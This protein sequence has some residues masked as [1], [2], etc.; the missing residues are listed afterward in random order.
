MDRPLQ[1]LRTLPVWLDILKD[2]ERLAPR[3][4]VMNYTNPVSLTVLAGVRAS[5]LH[6]VGL[7]HSIQ[8]TSQQL[9]DYLGLP[10]EEIDWRAA[11]INH[12]SWFVQLR[13]R[14]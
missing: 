4:L 7:C 9:A 6:I 11:G 12:L 13:T 5:S 1:A 10:Y 14:S 3:A 2:I 8:H